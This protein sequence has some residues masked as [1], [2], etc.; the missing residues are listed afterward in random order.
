MT[1]NSQVGVSSFLP[2]SLLWPFRSAPRISASRRCRANVP[3]AE[4][5]PPVRSALK[6][7]LKTGWRVIGVSRVSRVKDRVAMARW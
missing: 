5:V 3:G 7:R 4:L 2:G 6:A 1:F